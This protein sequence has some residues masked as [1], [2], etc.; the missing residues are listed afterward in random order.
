MNEIVITTVALAL[1]IA[2]AWLVL[3]A[4]SMNIKRGS[5]SGLVQVLETTPLGP[6]ERVVLLRYRNQDYL[7]A[8]GSQ[9]IELLDKTASSQPGAENPEE[10]QNPL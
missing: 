9:H 2:L 7:V 4:L 5:K 10:Y 8:V 1:V 6:K 3:K